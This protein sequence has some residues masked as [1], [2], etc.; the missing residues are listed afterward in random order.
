[1][2]RGRE[3][4]LPLCQFPPLASPFP[5]RLHLRSRASLKVE[6][7]D[8]GFDV[9]QL[10]HGLNVTSELWEVERLNPE[11]E[12]QSDRCLTSSPPVLPAAMRRPLAVASAP[13]GGS[14]EQEQGAAQGGSEVLV[15]GRV[16]VYPASGEWRE[17]R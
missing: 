8:A 11:P 14:R 3:S 17:G 9:D 16:R 10:V 13:A 7:R 15:S 1:M 6:A 12:V 5:S 2:S 4:V